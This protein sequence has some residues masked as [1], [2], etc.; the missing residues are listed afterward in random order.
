M[1]NK[2]ETFKATAKNLGAAS[3][4]AEAKKE[5]GNTLAW[6]AFFIIK[7]GTTSER[8]QLSSLV[9]KD[10]ELNAYKAHVSKAR[11]VYDALEKT[12]SI[13]SKSGEFTKDMAESHSFDNLPQTV[14]LASLYS[15]TR[16]EVKAEQEAESREQQAL[17]LAAE[18]YGLTPQEIKA[19]DERD[20]QHYVTEGMVLL[21]E[22]EAQEAA[23]NL[24]AMVD[25]VKALIAALP[26][27]E[28]QQIADYMATLLA[29]AGSLQATA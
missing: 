21:N 25:K 13:V 16:S 8:R 22:Q 12:L 4:A 7:D 24:P 15:A 14:K 18:A 11:G 28:R 19:L 1:I 20:R 10:G 26:H 17:K 2:I 5:F 6:Q 29:P 23:A 27:A 9:A 3:Q